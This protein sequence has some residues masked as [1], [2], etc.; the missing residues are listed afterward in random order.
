MSA[1]QVNAVQ[2]ISGAFS[3]SGRFGLA[4]LLSRAYPSQIPGIAFQIVRRINELAGDEYIGDE[5][6]RLINWLM[7]L[8]DGKYSQV[9]KG[10]LAAE[11]T[12]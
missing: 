11:A 5:D 8:A 12:V 7:L 3:R 2:V 6:A 9:L 4:S 1:A 10:A